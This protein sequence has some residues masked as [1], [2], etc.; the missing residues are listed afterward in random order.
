MCLSKS[1]R[2]QSVRSKSFSGQ[3]RV[4]G[5]SFSSQHKLRMICTVRAAKGLHNRAI[6]SVHREGEIRSLMRTL[7]RPMF[8]PK[9]RRRK[10]EVGVYISACRKVVQWQLGAD[11]TWTCA[12]CKQ[13]LEAVNFNFL[14]V[15]APH[16]HGAETCC[17]TF[18]ILPVF[19]HEDHIMMMQS[20]EGIN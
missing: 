4:L 8:E 6:V 1:K 9:W 11:A 18:S 17:I 19:S 14:F 3:Q 10:H 12:S 2:S 16:V 7:P 13:S 20:V 15:R 5:T